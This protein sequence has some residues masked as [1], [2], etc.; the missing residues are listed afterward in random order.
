MSYDRHVGVF[1]PEGRIY[2]TEYALKSVQLSLTS[3]CV[4]SKGQT[5]LAAE[6]ISQ[7]L[8]AAK[9]PF[10]KISDSIYA[11]SS[12][13]SSDISLVYTQLRSISLNHKFNFGSEISLQ[14]LANQIANFMSNFGRS[15]SKKAAM[16]RPF[17]CA[18]LL[19]QKG[20]CF[21]V[22]AAGNAQEWLGKAIGAGAA[23]GQEEIERLFGNS[24]F[25]VEMVK[26]VMG[27]VVEG[28]YSV[29]VLGQD[30]FK[31]VFEKGL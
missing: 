24:E 9:S 30:G 11:V 3:L 2:Q 5:I 10:A 18:I 14:Q 25:G 19:C 8:A 22:D 27:E 16:G 23:S 15:S 29:A 7:P 21:C 20:R 12:G 4:T 26:G 13:Y 6:T 17:G 31:V 28:G 1:S